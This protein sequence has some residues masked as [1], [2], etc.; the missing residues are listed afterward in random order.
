M[1]GGG[2]RRSRR[3]AGS[4]LPRSTTSCPMSRPGTS[5]PWPRPPRPT[6]SGIERY[7]SCRCRRRPIGHGPA[8]TVHRAGIPRAPES[9]FAP[10][11]YICYRT[12]S[13]LV[14]DGRLDEPTWN[15][16]AW[17]SD[18]VDIEGSLKP[19]PRFRTRAKLLWDAAY[20]YI[21]A[22]LDE[23]DVWATLTARDSV[24]FQDNDFEVFIDTRGDT[25]CYYELE[26]NALGTEWDLLLVKPYRDGGPA[27]HAW[28]IRGLKTKVAWTGRSTARRQ[29]QGLDGRDR[30]AARDPQGSLGREK[31]AG[32]GR[33]VA[34]EFLPGGVSGRGPRRKICQSEGSADGKI[35]SR[36][37]LDLGAPGRHQHPLPGNV[38]LP[39]VFRTE[40]RRRKREFVSRPEEA[41]KWALRQ[42]YYKQKTHS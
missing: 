9:P 21:G 1:S 28:D 33:P 18:F 24:I 41:A 34:P 42:V 16:A 4:S 10:P 11:H 22:E 20:L 27:I 12:P 26:M 7:I 19:K 30:P 17:T 32:P 29:G 37:Q 40:R 5:W 3:A 39:P 6:G 15:R 14:I 25:H 31:A 23:P 38:G 2:S 13:P 8:S 36:R 35:A